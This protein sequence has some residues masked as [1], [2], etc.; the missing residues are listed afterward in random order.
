MVVKITT[1]QR[2]E[3]FR[4]QLASVHRSE[5]EELIEARY[6]K[7]VW[8]FA[9]LNTFKVRCTCDECAPHL[10]PGRC[11]RH[12]GFVILPAKPGRPLRPGKAHNRYEPLQ[13]ARC[14]V[15]VMT[16]PWKDFTE[17]Q[18]SAVHQFRYNWE[19]RWK[20]Y[21][22][23]P[24]TTS[25][26]KIDE[27]GK[28]K[29]RPNKVRKENLVIRDI[30]LVLNTI[31]FSMPKETNLWTVVS[32]EKFVYSIEWRKDM[33]THVLGQTCDL[34]SNIGIHIHPD[35][36]AQKN[37]SPEELAMERLFVLIHELAHA[38][39]HAFACYAEGCEQNAINVGAYE[40]HG[41]A[42]HLILKAALETMWDFFELDLED[43]NAREATRILG[44]PSW[45]GHSLHD[46]ES[47]GLLK[48]STVIEDDDDTDSS[49]GTDCSSGADSELEELDISALK[50]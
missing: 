27:D 36:W 20:Q 23:G 28:V 21:L 31:F 30:A 40:G 25:E 41:R 1:Q 2:I 29:E 22:S 47:F 50:I 42:F 34:R 6:G 45:P 43:G 3:E 38:V 37:Y 33:E 7:F 19:K 8:R 35:H 46:L 15:D 18:K 4:K 17:D 11:R 12:R 24:I 9:N 16:R 5:R 14:V 44:R 13:L 26:L 49:G 32:A 48:D 10:Y 39:L